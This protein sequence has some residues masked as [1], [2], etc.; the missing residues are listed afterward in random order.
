VKGAKIKRAKGVVKKNTWKK[1]KYSQTKGTDTIHYIMSNVI[2][3][4]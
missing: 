3:C 2:S 4:P 1:K